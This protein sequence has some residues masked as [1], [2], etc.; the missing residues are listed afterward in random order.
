MIQAWTTIHHCKTDHV[1]RAMPA[2]TSL[3]LAGSFG[4]I[5]HSHVHGLSSPPATQP[6]CCQPG[7]GGAMGPSPQGMEEDIGLADSGGQSFR[8]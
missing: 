6:A 1:G 5:A 2:V 3:G 4:S 7:C 8:V